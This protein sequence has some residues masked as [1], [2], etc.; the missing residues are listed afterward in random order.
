MPWPQ[1]IDKALREHCN[2]PA[3]AYFVGVVL[4]NGETATFSGPGQRIVPSLVNRFFD[5]DGFARCVEQVESGG[6]LNYG[7]SPCLGAIT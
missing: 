4:D 5:A 6:E 2:I 7:S 1:G 3:K